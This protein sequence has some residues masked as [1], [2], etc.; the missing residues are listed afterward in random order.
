VQPAHRANNSAALVVPN[1]K[2]RMEAEHSILLVSLHDLLWGSFPFTLSCMMLKVMKALA[3]YVK[4]VC[5]SRVEYTMYDTGGL[6][7]FSTSN[8]DL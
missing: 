1:V 6:R 2:A 8:N 5:I 4:K 3:E 7:T